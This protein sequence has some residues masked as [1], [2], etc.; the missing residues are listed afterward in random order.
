[1]RS[2]DLQL[3]EQHLDGTLAE[4]DVARLEKLLLEDGEARAML[5]TLATLDLGLHD[6][7][8]GQQLHRNKELFETRSIP[9][10][11]TTS[12][13]FSASWTRSLLAIATLAIIGLGTALWFQSSGSSAESAAGRSIAKVTGTGGEV[14]FTGNG[15]FVTTDLKRGTLLTGGTIEGSSPTSWVELECLDGSRVTVAGDSRLTFSDFDQKVLYLN[16]GSVASSV[17]PQNPDSPMLVYTRNAMLEVLGTE[18]EV[19]SDVESTSLDV[20]EGKVRFKR[21]SDGQTVEV[22]AN[23]R[24]QSAE[25]LELSAQPIPDRTSQWEINLN[26]PHGM[27]GKWIPS[28][29]SLPPRLKLV[30]YWHKSP[31]AGSILIK[32][33]SMPVV[34]KDNQRVVLRPGS[35]LRVRGFAKANQKT[36]FGFVV[37]NNNGDF[38]GYYVSSK[39]KVYWMD[40]QTNDE[41]RSGDLQSFEF[42][43]DADDLCRGQD[44]DSQHFAS[45]PVGLVADTF[46]CSTPPEDSDLEITEVEIFNQM[47]IE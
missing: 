41:S 26:H 15:G 4:G 5:R 32:S 19:E 13:S 18:F 11:R 45:T 20:T 31:K 47:Q 17:K 34:G 9:P 16:D 22:P 3:L 27:T 7:A 38:G 1:M 12:S 28:T 14:A 33:A 39:P 25:G 44:L 40:L 37:R 30:H 23:Q 35:M 2:E 24:V 42:V 46:F 43:I 6:I 8:L 36:V 21:L 29:E 10:G